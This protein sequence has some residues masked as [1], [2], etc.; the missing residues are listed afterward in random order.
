[1][2]DLFTPPLPVAEIRALIE[3]LDDLDGPNPCAAFYALMA[4]K[5]KAKLCHYGGAGAP[6]YT[7][8]I[9]GYGL[10]GTGE[11]LPEALGDWLRQARGMTAS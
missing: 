1:M 6:G 11:T 9:A 4:E 5:P 3:R 2:N 10:T 7:H 8:R